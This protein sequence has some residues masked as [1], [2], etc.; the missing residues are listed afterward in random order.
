MPFLLPLGILTWEDA[1]RSSPL[2]DGAA[3][4][5]G[6]EGAFCGAKGVLGLQLQIMEAGLGKRSPTHLGRGLTTL[7]QMQ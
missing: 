4:W 5:N 7:A 3:H 6:A 1:E 2:G